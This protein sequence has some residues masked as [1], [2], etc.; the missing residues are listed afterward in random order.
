M[1]DKKVHVDPRAAE[2]GRRR[3]RE[4]NEQK[5]RELEEKI[6]EEEQRAHALFRKYDHDRKERIR[7]EIVEKQKRLQQEEAE[8]SRRELEEERIALKLQD[9]LQVYKFGNKIGKDIFADFDISDIE[10]VNIAIIGPAGSGK[11]CFIGE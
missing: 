3:A 4:E 9:S 1:Y 5:L 8:R 7:S 11:S 10:K 6:K 2:E